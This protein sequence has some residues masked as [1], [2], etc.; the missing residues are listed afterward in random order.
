MARVLALS[1]AI[2]IT[3]AGFP[4]YGIPSVSNSDR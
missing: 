4:T 1:A 2:A 3:S